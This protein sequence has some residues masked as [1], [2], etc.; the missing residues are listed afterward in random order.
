VKGR[1]TGITERSIDFIKSL[2]GMDKAGVCSLRAAEG[3]IKRDIR[4]ESSKLAKDC[5]QIAFVIF[6]IGHLLVSTLDEVLLLS[7]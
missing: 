3:F 7:N 2:L 1:D 6:V 5:F 4:D